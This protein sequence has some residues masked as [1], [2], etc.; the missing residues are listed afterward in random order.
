[1]IVFRICE[2]CGVIVILGI[3]R[4]F[5]LQDHR[6]A[7]RCMAKELYPIPVYMEKKCGLYIIIVYIQCFTNVF[8]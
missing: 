4:V 8:F 2:K 5:Q 7:L 6:I 1:M 3:M